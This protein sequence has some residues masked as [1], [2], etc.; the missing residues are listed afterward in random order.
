MRAFMLPMAV[1]LA[2]LFVTTTA[3]PSHHRGCIW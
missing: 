3:Y 1:L 2:A